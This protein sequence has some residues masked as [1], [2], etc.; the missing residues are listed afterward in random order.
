MNAFGT[1]TAI[2]TEFGVSRQYLSRLC[3][4]GRIPF[5]RQ[6][7]TSGGPS[8]LMVTHMDVAALFLETGAL[9]VHDCACSQGGYQDGKEEMLGKV[10]ALESENEALR[11][12]LASTRGEL[13]DALKPGVQDTVPNTATPASH[14]A[15]SRTSTSSPPAPPVATR[16][17]TS[18]PEEREE[19]YEESLRQVLGDPWPATD[20]RGKAAGQESEG[21][22]ET[23][24]RRPQPARRVVRVSQE[25]GTPRHSPPQTQGWHGQ[26]RWRP[27]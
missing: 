26:R 20:R 1:A 23:E 18:T 14:D 9:D 4:E 6:E 10:R 21:K 22:T 16:K 2:A 17:P 15:A 5:W 7:S 12:A 8:R 3:A 27:G 13:A 11:T 25:V 24:R 19:A